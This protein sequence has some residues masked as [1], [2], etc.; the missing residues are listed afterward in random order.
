MSTSVRLHVNVDHVATVRQ[1][2][3]GEQ[4]DPL[5]AARLALAHGADGITFHLREDRRHIN[6]ADARRLVEGVAGV[7]N[8][9]CAAREDVIDLA[10]ALRPTHATLVP[11]R[12]EELTTEGGLTLEGNDPHLRRALTRLAEAGIAVALFI[13]P[14]LHTIDRAADLGVTAVEL[15]T[16]RYAHQGGP[17]S[18]L[19]QLRRGAEHART[20]GL[21]VHAG[22]GL[23][24]GNV[25]AVA[26]LDP[27]EEL[28]IGHS[29][30]ARSITIGIGAATREMRRCIDEA[31]R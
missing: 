16:G 2:R 3:R 10:C 19:D 14:D 30:V 26:A 5:D 12:R 25:A 22:H 4:P 9:E 7:T 24:T 27:I 13:D 6:D 17:G 29:I 28:N 8:F 20:R 31:R 1:A 21:A 23:T 11:E 18:A 15:H